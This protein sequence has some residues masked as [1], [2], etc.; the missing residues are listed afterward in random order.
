MLHSLPS[1][2]LTT[3]SSDSSVAILRNPVLAIKLTFSFVFALLLS[4]VAFAS[5]VYSGGIRQMIVFFGKDIEVLTLGI[6]LFVVSFH[7][8]YLSLRFNIA[9]SLYRV[10]QLGFAFG[11]LLWAPASEQWGRRNIFLISYFPFVL[12][13]IGCARAQNIETMLVCRF[14]AGTSR[15]PSPLLSCH[16]RIQELTSNFAKCRFLR[17]FSPY[18]LRRSYQ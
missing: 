11:P 12:F 7:L 14:F 16:Q 4:G 1:V 18:Q 8:Q 3:R 9:H 15:K 2:S 5:S 13:N 17:I 10:V 6:S